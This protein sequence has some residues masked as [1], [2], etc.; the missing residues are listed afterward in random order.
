MG[1]SSQDIFWAPP[2]A[3]SAGYKKNSLPPMLV[4]GLFRVILMG[5]PEARQGQ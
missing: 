4:A 1:F 2:R 3:Q 5:S